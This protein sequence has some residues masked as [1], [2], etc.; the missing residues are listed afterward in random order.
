MI[1]Q[2]LQEDEYSIMIDNE[3]NRKKN[4]HIRLNSGNSRTTIMAANRN[5]ENDDE[6]L[7]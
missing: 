4:H 7:I 3:W 2:W 1:S 6:S 5:A